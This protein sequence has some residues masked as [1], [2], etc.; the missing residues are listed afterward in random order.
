MLDFLCDIFYIIGNIQIEVLL[1]ER[2]EWTIRVPCG[3]N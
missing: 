2:K 1:K 3:R